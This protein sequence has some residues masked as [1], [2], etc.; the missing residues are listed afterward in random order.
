MSYNGLMFALL[1]LPS[2]LASAAHAKEVDI[3]REEWRVIGWNAACGVAY[4]HLG[5]PKLGQAIAS[6]PVF[7]RIGAASIKTGAEKPSFDWS[8]EADGALTWNASEAAQAEKDLRQSGFSR[9]GIPEQL[10]EP[11]PGAPPALGD[12]LTS[13]AAFASRLVGA[14]PRAPWRLR[15]VDYNPL[16]TCA[17][18]VF[19]DRAA[20]RHYRL[21]LTRLYN[22]R[23]R[24]DRAAAHTALARL[25]FNGG[26]VEGAE[27]E[28]AAAARLSP[29][30]A[31]ARYEHGVM[32][33]LLGHSDE[34]VTEISA[35]VRLDAKMAARAKV[36][37]D[38]ADLRDRDDFSAVLRH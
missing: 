21:V 34:A 5:Y 37:E 28:A 15:A 20:P 2:F 26:D 29:E 23:S 14:W 8:I 27:A 33:A 4:S 16:S 25:I 24:R 22:S 18:V 6:E 36:D 17:L 31:E 38:L 35:A 30:S 11:P 1:L 19:E 7:T 12:T 10:R 9:A 3:A 32:L 13:T